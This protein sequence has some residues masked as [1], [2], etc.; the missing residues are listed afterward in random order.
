MQ[1]ICRQCQASFE[2]TPEETRLRE[3]I[4]SLLEVGPVPPRTLCFPCMI[5][6]KMVWRNERVL[7]KRTSNLSGKEIISM[8]PEGTP[9]PVYERGEWWSD[10]WDP[11]E[12]GQA[13]DFSRPFFEQFAELQAK[14][15]R[16]A[17]V[18]SNAP[19]CDYC[20]FVIDSRN[21]YLS[22]CTYFSE[23]LLYCYFS[24]FCKDCTDCA[25]CFQCE[26]CLACTDCNHSHGC[27]SCVLSHSCSDCS[28]L[29]DCRGCQKCFCCTGLRNKSYCMFN[30]ELEKSEYERRLQEF[31]LQ[32]PAH[33]AAVER[34][35]RE[36]R[37]RHPH[38]YSVQEKT[39]HCTGDY[40]FESKNCLDCYQV[41][42]GEDC[43]F[44]HDADEIK[45]VLH[46]YHA[47][48]SE[49]LYDVYSTSYLRN[50]AFTAQCWDG[51][52]VF[53]SAICHFSSHCFGCISLRHK[54]W[55]ILNRQYSKEDYLALL[56][57]ITEHMKHTNE[58]GEFF[59][60]TLSPYCYNETMAQEY[61]PM[62]KENVMKHGWRWRAELPFTQG[63]ETT[64]WDQVPERI[65]DVPDSI[66]Q[67]ILACEATGKN[68]RITKQELDF[69]RK[70]KLP[71]PR[72]HPDERHRRRMALRNPRMLFARACAKCGK[73]IQTTY[74]PER[75]EI[76]YCEECYLKAVY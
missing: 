64:T 6:R 32:N 74:S 60:V 5:V 10:H 48:W 18:A 3:K 17:L 34:R 52:D 61:F 63:R 41:Y 50:S 43:L 46:C 75:P 20:N 33:V 56:P 69:Y 30:E 62:M 21:C 8:Y 45:D 58:F 9:F 14:V 16:S 37:L 22:H 73:E 54:Q 71:L 67:E 23:S 31:D 59:P 42:R 72:L 68:Y 55:C 26:Q 27:V 7:Y 13:F 38:L 70:K 15:P 36:V 66:V 76:V 35:L 25:Y 2:I 39:E 19:N 40:V 11:L 65:E 28:Y 51:S 4:G 1:S 12:Y 49:V 47:G 29:Y 57:R 24:L 53:Y 44:Q